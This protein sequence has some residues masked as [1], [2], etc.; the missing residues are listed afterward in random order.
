MADIIKPGKQNNTQMV[1]DTGT[2][3][4]EA[5]LNAAREA[6]R[7]L[8]VKP[9]KQKQNPQ[10][11]AP[12]PITQNTMVSDT[13]TSAREPIKLPT[14]IKPSQQPV[15]TPTVSVEKP[16]ARRDRLST[17]LGSGYESKSALDFYA[18]VGAKTGPAG[19]VKPRSQNL[20]DLR[21]QLARMETAQIKP[22]WDQYVKA[23]E[24]YKAGTITREEYTDFRRAY[25]AA[26]NQYDPMYRAFEALKAGVNRDYWNTAELEEAEA[27][28]YYLDDVLDAG[29]GNL[30]ALY[31]KLS[32]ASGEYES[33]LKAFV[34]DKTEKNLQA[35]YDAYDQ[36][37]KMLGDYQAQEF[38]LR[39][40]YDI[41]NA[42][43]EKFRERYLDA[44]PEILWNAKSDSKSYKDLFDLVDGLSN[45]LA[46]ETDAEKRVQ[47]VKEIN[48]YETL[49]DTGAALSDLGGSEGYTEAIDFITERRDND[50]RVVLALKA[51]QA[52]QLAESGAPLTDEQWELIDHYDEYKDASNRYQ[53]W[54]QKLRNRRYEIEMD[55]AISQM[56]E[57]VQKAADAYVEAIS[58]PESRSA[59]S[60]L[61]DDAIH[62]Y[63]AFVEAAKKDGLSFAE[64]N[65]LDK[66]LRYEANAIAADQ[67]REEWRTAAMYNI[68]T[69]NNPSRL[70]SL[71]QM[72]GNLLASTATSL[73]SVVGPLDT[74]LQNMDSPSWWSE[75]LTEHNEAIDFNSPAHWHYIV[76]SAISEGDSARRYMRDVMNNADLEK[77][78]AEAQ[79]RF[80][81]LTRIYK[82]EG[83]ELPENI[84]NDILLQEME[85]A[86][87]R[88]IAESKAKV[89]DFFYGVLQSM[90]QS[91]AIAAASLLFGPGS[92]A[93]LSMSA[94]EA[95]MQEMHSK[96]YSDDAAIVGG[97]I[98]G[99][100]EYA[101]EKWSIEG[102]L[103]ARARGIRAGSDSWDTL[104]E[105]GLTTGKQF[106]S[107]A[108][109][110]GASTILNTLADETLSRL[111]NGGLS[112]IEQD[113]LALQ[114]ANPGMSWSDAL[115][116]C[117]GDW[118]KGLGSDML[119]GAVSGGLSAPG[120]FGVNAITSS[121]ESRRT[122]RAEGARI[123]SDPN[124]YIT[125]VENARTFAE[126]FNR[127]KNALER[128][129]TGSALQIGRLLEENA[130]S[131]TEST[132]E[133]RLV[134]LGEKNISE[135]LLRA[136][137]VQAANQHLSRAERAA[138]QNS[139]FGGQVARELGVY[140]NALQTAAE[141][142]TEAD[143][144]GVED[145][146]IDAMEGAEMYKF[147][148][149]NSREANENIAKWRSR[150][151]EARYK[152]LQAENPDS[153]VLKPIADRLS[154]RGA[155][156]EYAQKQGALIE[157][158]LNGEKLN[159]KEMRAFDLA[160]TAVRE[161]FKELTGMD[162]IPDNVT[163]QLKV[164][165]AN[166]VANEAALI[167]ER[168]AE[169]KEAANQPVETKKDT[170]PVKETESIEKS[171]K[172]AESG[173]SRK[174]NA[175]NR[176][177]QGRRTA[178]AD[179]AQAHR[180]D[181]I[182]TEGRSVEDVFEQ[183][184][185]QSGIEDIPTLAEFTAEEERTMLSNGANE[186]LGVEGR[187]W[188]RL[189][190]IGL[191][192]A[193]VEALIRVQ[194][195]QSLTSAGGEQYNGTKEATDN[196][197]RRA[198]SGTDSEGR[199]AGT[200]RESTEPVV[201]KSGTG[202]EGVSD[203]E[204]SG[205]SGRRGRSADVLNSTAVSPKT[206]FPNST[207]LVDTAHIHMIPM[208]EVVTAAGTPGRWGELFRVTQ[209]LKSIGVTDIHFALADDNRIL[210]YKTDGKTITNEVGHH[211]NGRILVLA[212]FDGMDQH[213]NPVKVTF[214]EAGHALMRQHKGLLDALID[215]I[216]DSEYDIA[217]NT[218]A[219]AYEKI[220]GYG[221]TIRFSGRD[222][223]RK[224]Q[225]EVINDI[226]AGITRKEVKGLRL[227]EIRPLIQRIVKQ[228]VPGYSANQH[229]LITREANK[230]YDPKTQAQEQID[231][232][233]YEKP[234]IKQSKEVPPPPMP[235]E[236]PKMPP[237]PE[238]KPAPKPA[239]KP[240]ERRTP[241][242]AGQRQTAQTPA[243][244]Q[245]QQRGA[246]TLGGNRNTTQNNQWPLPTIDSKKRWAK[247]PEDMRRIDSTGLARLRLEDPGVDLV[248]AK[249]IVKGNSKEANAVRNYVKNYGPVVFV[250]REG[251]PKTTRFA[252]NGSPTVRFV[253]GL[254]YVTVTGTETPA[255]M[256]SRLRQAAFDQLNYQL[257]D[258]TDSSTRKT[259]QLVPSIMVKLSSQG[260]G[261]DSPVGQLFGAYTFTGED[262]TSIIWPVLQTLYGNEAKA[263][264]ILTDCHLDITRGMVAQ[265]LAWQ[266]DR[267]NLAQAVKKGGPLEK[268]S[269]IPGWLAKM[270]KLISP[271]AMAL[272]ESSNV[273]EGS[274]NTP[275]PENQVLERV[276]DNDKAMAQQRNFR[277][278][279]MYQLLRDIYAG[280][281]FEAKL[282]PFRYT[283]EV[284]RE[285]A[286]GPKHARQVESADY[287]KAKN[288]LDGMLEQRGSIVTAVDSL[289]GEK[290]YQTLSKKASTLYKQSLA[291][292]A[293]RSE[294]AKKWFAENMWEAKNPP[295]KIKQK[296]IE[297]LFKSAYGFAVSYGKAATDLAR[298]D[299]TIRALNNQRYAA[300]REEVTGK[301]VDDSEYEATMQ[302]EE[303]SQVKN[304]WDQDEVE[305]VGVVD[306]NDPNYNTAEFLSTD[307]EAADI[308]ILFEEELKKL[309][310]KGVKGAAD[311][312]SKAYEN[313]W[314]KAIERYDKGERPSQKQTEAAT[315]TTE[316][317]GQ[318]GAGKPTGAE[319]MAIMATLRPLYSARTKL[320]NNLSSIE[321]SF[322]GNIIDRQIGEL[323]D[324][325]YI[326]F[327][328]KLAQEIL[329]GNLTPEQA[330]NA[331][332]GV[333]DTW[334]K[335]PYI[336][337]N[338]LMGRLRTENNMESA[339]ANAESVA[340]GEAKLAEDKA[341]A[342][343]STADLVAGILGGS[344]PTASEQKAE[345]KKAADWTKG[346]LGIAEA[347]ARNAGDKFSEAD[348]PG[349]ITNAQSGADEDSFIAGLSAKLDTIKPE[350]LKTLPEALKLD[351]AGASARETWKKT[352]WWRGQEG[353][354][355]VEIS[356]E[357]ASLIAPE[358]LK[359]TVS[360]GLSDLIKHD[361]LFRAYPELK[362][363]RVVFSILP[364]GTL[365]VASTWFNA[366]GVKQRA[367]TLSQHYRNSDVIGSEDGR[368]E[369]LRTIL[370]EVQHFIQNIE[371]FLPGSSSEFWEQYM[372]DRVGKVMSGDEIKS[373]LSEAKSDLVVLGFTMGSDL[374]QKVKDVLSARENA[375]FSGVITDPWTGEVVK[376]D[377]NVQDV[378]EY[379]GDALENLA[380]TEEELQDVYELVQLI[381][382]IGQL[383][384][385]DI[386]FNGRTPFQMYWNYPGEVESREVEKR[387][388]FTEEGRR[389]IAPKL[390]E[391]E[392]ASDAEYDWDFDDE[393]SELPAASETPKPLTGMTAK[394]GEFDAELR[395]RAREVEAKKAEASRRSDIV[396]A[397]DDAKVEAG[398]TESDRSES[399]PTQVRNE[400]ID[401]YREMGA[402]PTQAPAGY[403]PELER[404][405]TLSPRV[406]KTLA[407]VHRMGN[408]NSKQTVQEGMALWDGPISTQTA[409]Q[410]KS[411]VLD[412]MKWA[413][414]KFQYL[415]YSDCYDLERFGKL[416]TRK[417]NVGNLINVTRSSNET[418]QYIMME[419]FVDQ[420]GN[421]IGKPLR[422]VVLCWDEISKEVDQDKQTLF[423]R[424]LLL[425]HT[426]DR[427]S[428]VERALQKVTAY[429]KTYPE[430]SGMTAQQIAE[431]IVRD[432][433]PVVKEY[434]RLLKWAEGAED[435][436]VLGM[437][438]GEIVDADESAGVEAINAA[439]AQ[440]MADDML[441]DNPWLA[442]KAQE[443][444]DWWDVFMRRWGIGGE[445]T[446][447]DYA[448]IR[449]AYPHY[450][451]T[452]RDNDGF[453][454]GKFLINRSS[455]FSVG[456]RLRK[457]KGSILSIA[458]IED[459][460]ATLTAKYVQANR[461]N[462]LIRNIM[463]EFLL[464]GKDGTL[465]FGEFGRIDW[466]STSKE[467]STMRAEDNGDPMT[468]ALEHDE[469][470]HEYRLNCWINGQKV[471]AL[472]SKDF[473]NSLRNLFKMQGEAYKTIGS[474]GRFITSPSKQFITGANPFFA[475]RNV[476]ADLPTAAINTEAK[477]MIQFGA[478][479]VDAA[480][481]MAQNSDAW[482]QFQ[483]MGGT[484]SD[485]V[486][487]NKNFS[488]AAMRQKGAVDRFMEILGIPGEW[489]ESVTR[490]AEYL[491]TINKLGD[492]YESRM[493]AMKN[494]AEVTV[495]FSRAG[496]LAR[497]LNQWVPYFNPGVQGVYKVFRS[498]F[499]APD[500]KTMITHGGK[501]MLRA[502]LTTLP[503]E[504]ILAAFRAAK[505]REKD[506]EEVSEYIK[507]NYYLI[508]MDDNKW[509][510]IRKNREWAA[511]FGNMT[512][513]LLEQNNGYP[514]A[515]KS[516][517]DISIKGNFLPD[518]P[519]PLGLAQTIELLR[520]ENFYGSAIIPYTYD[521]FKEEHPTAV[522]DENTSVL[523]V[524]LSNI[525]A[526][527][528][529]SANPMAVD[530]F[531]KS[532]MGDFYSR[533][534]TGITV[535]D[536][537]KFEDEQGEEYYDLTW[538]LS[539]FSSGEGPSSES[540]WQAAKTYAEG[541]V[542]QQKQSWI[543]D[544]RYS[545]S[546]MSRYYDIV[547]K[548]KSDVALQQHMNGGKTNSIEEQTQT[549]LSNH[550]YGY[551]YLMTQLAK[552]ARALP[553]GDEK[554]V[555]KTQQVVLAHQAIDFYNRC[556]SGEITD[557]ERYIKYMGLD[558]SVSSELTRLGYLADNEDMVYEPTFS[559]LS[560]IT[561]P[562]KSGNQ[563]KLTDQQ[564]D[565]FIKV[566]EQTY[567][568]EIKNIIGSSEYKSY[569]DERKASI[570]AEARS[571]IRAKAV[572][573]F[574]DTLRKAGT[575]SEP[576]TLA[577]E[578]MLQLEGR[579]ALARINTPEYAVGAKVSD[580]LV[581][582]H[583]YATDYSFAMSNSKPTVFSPSTGS[584]KVYQL[585]GTQQNYYAQLRSQLYNEA[586]EEVM[587]S[588]EYRRRSDKEKAAMLEAT[589]DVVS[590]RLKDE[591]QTYLSENGATM[592]PR[593]EL[594]ERILAKDAEY[595]VTTILTPKDAYSPQVYNELLNLY[596]YSDDYSF[597]PSTYM[598]TG[599]DDPKKKGYRYYLTEGQRQKY[600]EMAHYWYEQGF[601][602]VM[603]SSV[604][605]TATRQKKAE[606]LD[607][608]RSSLADQVK[609]NFLDWLSENATSQ[610]KA[611]TS[612]EKELKKQV[613]AICGW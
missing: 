567:S 551:M 501:T 231:K 61:H 342:E 584:K 587:Y 382:E 530:Y 116:Q 17:S 570:L 568:D 70:R 135:D 102:L 520:N 442:D 369:L 478:S 330:A 171:H 225:E 588:D 412:F 191:R 332:L 16:S 397:V 525:F 79:K 273:Y 609:K 301:H 498:V 444:Y 574:V 556:M 406:R 269:Y 576:R 158:L 365:G 513:R 186:T 168:Q 71:L 423:N 419:S 218:A 127:V 585:D 198:E 427:M 379:Y 605:R 222:L 204:A 278:W 344:E 92:M 31:D 248:L 140:A 149:L 403:D 531:I 27:N 98:S 105:L 527:A 228:Y 144:S 371:G 529:K 320:R 421:V 422:E 193:E 582:L 291:V 21:D 354:W 565:E 247:V 126:D 377:A 189:V 143:L 7:P 561:D 603:D 226:F 311:S 495:D 219:D 461:S 296:A 386:M 268:Y 180:D 572:S 434:Y 474:L 59:E 28:L 147:S 514:D 76:S 242:L 452:Y 524:A 261:P 32:A 536:I 466:D 575:K 463:E 399:S 281:D 440:K 599:Y 534:L 109:E 124:A 424:Y 333:R 176:Q 500:L 184:R 418:A 336:T 384:D 390:S 542:N 539:D 264:G 364:A 455:E 546:T 159:G 405:M 9:G 210:I 284:Y 274:G 123:L 173:N 376:D 437:L 12:A 41:R 443:L 601:N 578:E 558:S 114:K 532:Y 190:E 166:L 214:H 46:A 302:E 465:R 528:F 441:T 6:V 87:G 155:S 602:S 608:M 69:D 380:S 355:R 540:I 118:M 438:K 75:P 117:W 611:D 99:F 255:E 353:R 394:N 416:Q 277:E 131:I 150:G 174:A 49:L 258:N 389:S 195:E 129:G 303:R 110:E 373:R 152:Q 81:N 596:E 432:N 293:Q 426:V 317:A 560:Y 508:P 486:S 592:V 370:H 553:D 484:H 483:A 387:R 156:A 246:P 334:F 519:V 375:E 324:P 68:S 381:D 55:G 33:A 417:D 256:V 253:W 112:Q 259:A 468:S 43:G 566:W 506:F 182:T 275:D 502:A 356:D 435:K 162:G 400:L 113:A 521:D 343:K 170:L 215:A 217:F 134:T 550:T 89:G 178:A 454:P 480:R 96:G 544:S 562:D 45:D 482:I 473:Y 202:G 233:E 263:A 108:S 408:E 413:G 312:S 392:D 509:F 270:D 612:A 581:R 331:M 200:S 101:T 119:A 533:F 177:E 523:A 307:E 511:V 22:L 299:A 458:P 359:N 517:L 90:G 276:Y 5:G 479:W 234:I 496:Y 593:T 402:D 175:A 548:L 491:A 327:A 103:D 91:S 294:R 165:Y 607:A 72:G 314:Y 19:V 569:D 563:Y 328:T 86:G 313:A 571:D 600:V 526:T 282:A 64:I 211:S 221:N 44:H 216:S 518:T 3:N 323:L 153:T 238:Q 459:Q 84:Y 232:G 368:E 415:M 20:N 181:Y 446:E 451:P 304:L 510:K 493:I 157:K 257:R 212:E 15:S 537:R 352:G 362:Q 251:D 504:L 583:E 464:D 224:C 133:D 262:D 545:N 467:F 18:S 100:A 488:T 554:T 160:N 63:D 244:Q 35:A 279:A 507:D 213:N 316:E 347:A 25:Q 249:N 350:A 30:T 358:S 199:R 125:V 265:Y 252:G 338:E 111:L 130:K 606:L 456:P 547:E 490:F 236:K 322:K 372:T 66:Y 241:T 78:E 577:N 470:A 34:A 515:F 590:D 65:Q 179:T 57:D 106:L 485:L 47:L 425:M 280:T 83:R 220:V 469:K 360:L 597:Q 29:G 128:R 559:R 499:E 227:S 310:E 192:K 151:L 586:M 476:Q 48:Y 297:K 374:Y 8:V 146:A 107:E 555:I 188:N 50:P 541:F 591:F 2:G 272:Y 1:T 292:N 163:Y 321:T 169:I 348:V 196:A 505:G 436:P 398:K 11:G 552:Q 378:E 194:R 411:S 481:Q 266:G 51:E 335:D 598:P 120:W 492:S 543:T 339:K 38:V 420:Q 235:P 604:Y 97:I 37:T 298:I 13:G 300:L 36:Y 164:T 290:G 239:Q 115:G 74:L 208:E 145:W 393:D 385:I 240:Q 287:L 309:E 410:Q 260:I 95:T 613:K 462:T 4:A 207:K 557:P 305:G 471:S 396:K 595:A 136:I 363:V 67:L 289:M 139:K 453:S 53:V 167:K 39:E 460:F 447:E 589:A 428:I 245:G 395:E 564:K 433:N 429:E 58:T 329:H 60:D 409:Q 345:E 121:V 367:I 243:Q 337:V 183:V 80:D 285:E 497:L 250:N 489:S 283:E 94:A 414:N 254:S 26:Y 341:K 73:F 203:R 62:A 137:R 138:L 366:F 430:L 535:G 82:H 93:I 42:A 148:V 579:Y 141:N 185:K 201:E 516:Y 449:D 205:T 494:A 431:A 503:V 357:N 23:E 161:V 288:W 104:R 319:S 522:Y 229:N 306:I 487:T 230:F 477:W 52:K 318:P 267:E 383:E 445:I 351:K 439:T 391:F 388:K 24:A 10:T 475:L 172:R 295:F 404:V 538:D 549:A 122:A 401:H 472:V 132:I 40:M 154:N 573:K 340:R 187:Y 346:L 209:F 450:V 326:S 271:E 308:Q 594:D 197:D 88:E 361:D 54:I 457:A 512:M 237:K 349:R 610:P 286:D 448:N 325:A 315:E 580:E 407:N 85:K 14:V 77:A 142:E 56:S 223:T 206:L